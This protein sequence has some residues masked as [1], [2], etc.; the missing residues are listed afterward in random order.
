MTRQLPLL[1]ALVCVLVGPI[2][3]RPKNVGLF[4]PGERSVVIVTP[5][6]DSIRSEFGRA[7]EEW[8]LAHKGQRVH[9]DWR[10]PGGTSEITRYVDSEY[11]AAFQNYWT[12]TL[13]RPWSKV[14]EA[15]FLNRRVVPGPGPAKDTPEQQ[16]RR[17]FL[18]SHVSCKLDLFFGGG[19]YDFQQAAS[20]GLLVDCGYLRAHPEMFGD[21][22]GQIPKAL[23]GEA[24]WDPQGRW[25][26]TV[27][28]SFGI[29]YNPDALRRLGIGDPP[30]LWAD[31]ARPSYD[32]AIALANPTQ[33]SSV[34]R[35]F[36]ML[37][38]QQIQESI[39]AHHL[40]AG[41]EKEGVEEGWTQ[42]MRLLMKIGANA[43]YFTD[44]S[45]K[46]ALDVEAGEAAAG[47]TIDFYGRYESE[48]VRRPDGTSRLQY[49]NAEGGTSFGV[50][51]IGLYR[52]APDPEL[53][54]DFIAFVMSP[55]GQKLWNWKVGAPGGPQR[56]ALRRLPILPAL[57]APQ[58]AQF[59]TDPDVNPY[60][61]ART[62]VYHESWTS[63]LFRQ[64]A[65]IFRVMCIDAHEELD[66][67]WNAL[68][69]AHY[70]PEATKIFEDVS[71]IDYAA[72]NGRIRD[73]LGDKIREVQLARELSDHFR[74]QYHRA[75][76]AARNGR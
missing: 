5:H 54:R 18:D 41:Q 30:V 71:A 17:A 35:A 43:R 72:A 61:L 28:S 48:A 64:I 27:I 29:C 68:Q 75:A 42:A 67:A 3:L 2:L 74:D 50:D 6:N 12:A 70:P 55:E 32:H 46:I 57:Y 33:S 16:A 7:F 1:L 31:L 63:P 45:G 58:F 4:G 23:S 14:V 9:V 59:R 22:P 51:P 56:H 66:T 69:A 39:A 44:S 49:V 65:F 24:Y 40:P 11:L 34:T 37:I 8:Y 25:L 26:G 15:S 36:E 19:A 60:E 10:I 47:M 13:H 53:A 38:Q 52:G 73:A 21:K 76:E 20:K 62:F